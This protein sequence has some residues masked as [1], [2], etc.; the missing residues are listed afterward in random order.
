MDLGEF[1]SCVRIFEGL[2]CGKEGLDWFGIVLLEKK[3]IY[4]LRVYCVLEV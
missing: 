2:L 3:G 4:L 1:E